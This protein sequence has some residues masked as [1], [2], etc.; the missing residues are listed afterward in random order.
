LE[1]LW[2]RATEESIVANSAG[3]MGFVR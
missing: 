3:L 1:G 2:A